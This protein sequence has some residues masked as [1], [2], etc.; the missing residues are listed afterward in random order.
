MGEFF[1]LTGTNLS[2][3]DFSFLNLQKI[4]PILYTYRLN[5]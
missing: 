4:Y 1:N 3:L 2:N 5:E